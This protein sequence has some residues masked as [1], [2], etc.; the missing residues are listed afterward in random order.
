MDDTLYKKVA[1]YCINNLDFEEKSETFD[2]KY[3]CLPLCVVDSVFS[4]GVHYSGV[5]NAIS[6]FCDYY[7]IPEVASPITIIP[8][9]KKQ[10]S[11]TDFLNLLK[12]KTPEFIAKNI[13]TLQRTSSKNGILKAEATIRFLKVLKD[14]NIQYYQDVP[15]IVINQEFERSIKKIPGQKSGLSLKYFFMLAGNDN[16]IKPDRMIHRFLF[17]ATG[18]KFKDNECQIILTVVTKELN[19]KGYELTPKLLDDIIWNYQREVK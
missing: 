18:Q 19:K 4:I 13:L 6:R 10:I 2:N 5:E 12:K 8:S 15:K 11:T 14:F 1:K 3:S 7:K 17:S 16:L 9:K